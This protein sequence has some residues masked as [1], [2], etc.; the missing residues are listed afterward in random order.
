MKRLFAIAALTVGLT[1]FGTIS[2]ASAGDHYYSG[3]SAQHGNVYSG[4]GYSHGSY[5][6]GGYGHGVAQP[7]QQNYGS[8]YGNVPSYG[9]PNAGYSPIYQSG[10]RG[11]YA[12]S[13]GHSGGVHLDIGRFHILGHGHH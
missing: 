1:V 4:H 10:Y 12:P 9:Y 11:G 5:G 13:Y 7:Y 6:H 3:H 2:Q 8:Y